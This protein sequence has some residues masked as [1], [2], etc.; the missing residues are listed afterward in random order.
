MPIEFIRNN[1]LEIVIAALSG[2]MLVWFTVRKSGKVLSPALATQLMNR[3]DA[4]V[5]DV[6][7]A[8]EYSSGHLPGARNIPLKDLQ[9]RVGELETLK[10]KPL[11][12][13]C[14]SGARSDQACAQLRKL[15]FSQLNSLE[16]GVDAWVRAGLPVARGNKKK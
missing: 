7:D 13:V 10:D 9:A 2:G 5:V 1:I 3:E 14:A 12:L 11:L 4:I 16:G 6:R 8:H 15:G